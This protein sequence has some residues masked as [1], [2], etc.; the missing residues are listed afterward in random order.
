MRGSSAVRTGVVRD[1]PGKLWSR[2]GR[3]GGIE[4]ER[5]FSYYDG[6]GDGYAIQ[7]RHPRRFNRSVKLDELDGIRRPPQSFMYL[8][9]SVVRAL[10]EFL[11]A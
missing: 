1:S 10:L 6:K 2:F 3:V 11:P 8:D 5:F 4:R 9:P 7:V